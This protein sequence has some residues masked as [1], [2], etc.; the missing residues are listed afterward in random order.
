MRDRDGEKKSET[1]NQNK[2][3]VYVLLVWS[4]ILNGFVANSCGNSMPGKEF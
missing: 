3:N 1:K 4:I 2:S